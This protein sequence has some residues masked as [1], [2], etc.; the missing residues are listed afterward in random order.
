MA[1]R[2]RAVLH[3]ISPKMMA[4][5][6][7]VLLATSGIVSAIVHPLP[8]MTNMSGAHRVAITAVCVLGGIGIWAA[9]WDRWPPRAL[10][11][12]PALGLGVKMWANLLGGLGPYS[13]S[14]HFVL[15]YVW[16]GL[17]LPRWTPLAFSP[18]LAIAYSLPLLSRGDPIQS[19]SVA[20]VLPICVVIGESVGW[21]ANRLRYM[22][23]VNSKRMLGMKWLVRAS[24]DLAHQHERSETA[25]CVARLAAALPE[26]AGVA[27]LLRSP[28]RS[29]EMA[30]SVDWSGHFP[31][32]LELDRAPA[33]VAAMQSHDLV[34]RSEASCAELAAQLGVA[35]LG[36]AP[37]FVSSSCVG[38]VLLAREANAPPLDDFTQNLV[39][40][41]TVQAGLAMERVRERDKLRN[42]ALHDA[43]TGLGNRRKANVRLARLVPGDAVVLVDLDHFKRVNDTQGHACGDEVLK[44]FGAFLARSLRDYDEAFRIGGEE[45]LVV[46]ENSGKGAEIA[47]ERLCSGWRHQDPVTTFSAGIAVHIA[48]RTSA[49]ALDRADAAL[50]D[51]KR[52][53]RDRVAMAAA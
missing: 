33:L 32:G 8:N 34:G 1:D 30:A 47:G 16:I 45:F 37:I 24:A 4:R 25:E 39:R 40:T 31:S 18:L 51:A 27:V 3:T 21:I 46:L 42:D 41:L 17:A 36:I 44:S 49:E 35:R 22:E 53:G 43:L 6:F 2:H 15:V 28:D 14:I 29:F 19:A 11:M 38:L 13:Y 5:Y 26:A 48:G 50:Y 7:A 10:L 9:P 12:L 20:M 23:Q 52:A